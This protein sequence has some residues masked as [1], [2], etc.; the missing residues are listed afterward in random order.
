MPGMASKQAV[1][2]QAVIE[3]AAPEPNW[4][5]VALLGGLL[6]GFSLRLYRL[7]SESLWY[8]ETVSAYLAR[9]P[10]TQMIAHTA[11]D[12]HPPGYYALL[13]FWQ[14][15]SHPTLEHGLEFLFAWPSLWAG[16]LVLALLAPIGRRLLGERAAVLAIWLAAV[17]PFHLW[18][19][20]EVRMYTIGAALGLLCLWA[21]LR[22]FDQEPRAWGWLIVYVAA[23]ASGLYTLY[24]FSFAL[25][26][27][28]VLALIRLR[29]LEPAQRT[30]A[31][32]GWVGAQ[33]A[34]LLLWLPW[35]P[36]FLH[37][38]VSP[39]VPPW[40]APW[41]TIQAFLASL[42]ETLG[43]L[44]IGQSP[45]GGRM[46]PFA[47]VAL[48]AL[49][50][51]LWLWPGE[52]DERDQP[53]AR[54]TLLVY[55]F[56]PLGLLYLF[57]A[58]VTPLYHVRYVFLYA[59]PFMLIVAAAILALI[60]HKTWLALGALALM[61]GISTWGLYE[62]WS[63]PRYRADDHRTAV[64]DLA[65]NWRPDDLILANAGW[66]Y[67][68]LEI[69]WPTELAGPLASRPP[70]ITWDGRFTDYADQLP[71]GLSD[72]ELAAPV[73]IARTGSVDGDSELGWGNP[74]SDFFAVS[75][76]ETLAA[77]DTIGTVHP[78]LWH[79]RL[80]DTVSDPAG[81]IRAWLNQNGVLA[82]DLPYAGRDYLRVQRYDLAANPLTEQQMIP[83]DARF[84]D[85][86]HL[87]GR[88]PHTLV[89]AGETL[90]VDLYWEALTGIDDLGADL[91]FSLRLYEAGSDLLLVQQ[92]VAPQPPSSSW[93]PGTRVQQS[94]ALPV[95]IS[96]KPLRYTIELI[97]YRQDTG[98]PIV[99]AG[100]P[101]HVIDGQRW[102]IGMTEVFK[103][104]HPSEIT[105]R[106]ASFDYIDLTHAAL[107]RAESLPGDE[108]RAELIW[109]PNP[110]DY[111]DAYD[112]I[113]ELRG[114]DNDVAATWRQV[115]GGLNYPSSVWPAGYPLR[116][117]R[118][119][120]LPDDLAAGD[121]T[122]ALRMERASDGLE[123]NAETGLGRST[124]AVMI[125]T[126]R[127]TAP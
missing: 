74:A 70:A 111:R 87:V 76:A 106:L 75:A 110:S 120:P 43:A 54:S 4:L 91:S 94:F 65:R 86:L 8:D 79:Y 20:Q 81:V 117:V 44:I 82:Q 10:L 121:Y 19:G 90:Y 68:T 92:D 47:L 114:A 72:G 15:L 11:G 63:N 60:R 26:A 57:T 115:A 28:N 53:G 59:P 35:L 23:A 39:P 119:M 3:Q 12:I 85:A 6:L 64:A 116:E 30:R 18:Y 34:V 89:E 61:I 80:Y 32:L 5:R 124:D 51:F 13:H 41:S 36:V 126:L 16:V 45:P 46:W 95:P 84:G 101:A 27:L 113:I 55:I 69:Y 93:Q 71:A 50:L 109:Y 88:D 9:L 33:V 98:D 125:G 83:V 24:Y 58:T 103:S 73:I 37:Q 62:F 21:T 56:V 77:L 96:A 1:H 97:V 48:L 17:N 25:I 100:D 107:D 123:L 7:G 78:R 104:P 31:L 99:P 105:D 14:R 29:K 38:A 118:V 108:F 127:I 67:P 42:A 112:V 66:V 22:F 2:H 40:R 122:V 49:G 52:Q 102:R